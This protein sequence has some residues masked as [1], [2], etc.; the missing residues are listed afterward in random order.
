MFVQQPI[1][2]SNNTLKQNVKTSCCCFVY[3][4]EIF[5]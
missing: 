4:T 5:T 2:K 3:L 1:I